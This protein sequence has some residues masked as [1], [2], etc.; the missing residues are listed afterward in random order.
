VTG[1]Q[2][3]AD[4]TTREVVERFNEA[5]NRRDVAALRVSVT[6][7]CV[8]ES[9]GAPDGRR[10]VGPEMVAVF[11][12][13]FALE[14]EGPFEVEEIFTSGDRA[15]VRWTHSWDHPG[16]DRGHVRGIDLFRVR[17][18]RISEKLSYVKG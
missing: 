6:E 18:G 12:K 3:L 10:Y 2:A 15:V 7:D 17:D 5:V 8:F 11:A 14:G 4:V 16:G 13:V 1:V 9:P